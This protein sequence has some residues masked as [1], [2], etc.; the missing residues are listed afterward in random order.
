M[1]RKDVFL[2]HYNTHNYYYLVKIV[3]VRF[4]HN[5]DNLSAEKNN[6]HRQKID[7]NKTFKYTKFFSKLNVR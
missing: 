7:N 4:H 3:Y 5:P 6:I 2:L 1:D